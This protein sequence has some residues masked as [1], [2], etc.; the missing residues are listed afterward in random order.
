MTASEYTD[1]EI[2]KE[3]EARFLYHDDVDAMD[4]LLSIIDHNQNCNTLKPKYVC[5]D[6]VRTSLRRMLYYREDRE[7][8]I[9]AVLQGVHNDINRIE[10]SLYLD[11][12][13]EGYNYK[14]GVDLLE[15]E[16]LKRY[17]AASL[18]D[19]G[20]LYHETNDLKMR[21]LKKEILKN[22][23]DSNTAYYTLRLIENYCEK[24]MKPKIMQ[25]NKSMN[26]QLRFY[27]DSNKIYIHDEV[28]L[29]KKLLIK[30]YRRV[31]S[32]FTNVLLRTAANAVWYGV[33][34]RVLERYK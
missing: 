15:R 24:T 31:L 8:I 5:T 20:K 7:L 32:T 14:E 3:L 16:V 22:F 12:Y 11:Y 25:L 17:S 6:R 29:S 30:M 21:K 4:L 26:K 23:S 18:A 2:K 34:D 13:T 28:F 33:N 27:Y 9:S 19:K 10:F 1:I